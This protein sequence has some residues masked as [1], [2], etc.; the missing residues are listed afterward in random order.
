MMTEIIAGQNDSRRTL[1]YS[2]NEQL[3]VTTASS[4]ISDSKSRSSFILRNTSA[5]VADVI[6]VVLGKKAGVASKGIVLNKNEVYG[7]S[8]QEGFECW[9]GQINAICATVNGKLSINER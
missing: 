2:A 4:V 7:E 1:E 9:S 6:T 5:N 3:D 8:S